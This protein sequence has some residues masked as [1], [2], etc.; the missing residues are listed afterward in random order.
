MDGR[1]QED[2]TSWNEE[3]SSSTSDARFPFSSVHFIT[4]KS[5]SAY[6]THCDMLGSWGHPEA[7]PNTWQLDSYKPNR[8][9]HTASQSN[10]NTFKWLD[11][12]RFLSDVCSWDSW[13][14]VAAMPCDIIFNMAQ[15]QEQWRT[16]KWWRSCFHSKDTQCLRKGWTQQDKS[17]K[18]LTLLVPSCYVSAA[19]D[20][21]CYLCNWAISWLMSSNSFMPVNSP[22]P[23]ELELSCKERDRNRKRAR[24]GDDRLAE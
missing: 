22:E 4:K 3:S 13:L 2:E 16:W 15:T 21:V 5:V 10:Q 14:I 19:G 23:T 8:V 24:E 12:S 18:R 20:I 9:N 1:K 7:H 6:L 11:R 17:K